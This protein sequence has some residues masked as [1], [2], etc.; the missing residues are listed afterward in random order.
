MYLFV[1]KRAMPLLGTALHRSPGLLTGRFNRRR[2]WQQL[3]S[4]R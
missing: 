3:S 4:H 2:K 1:A